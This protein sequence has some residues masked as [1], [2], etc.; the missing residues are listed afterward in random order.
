MTQRPYKILLVEDNPGDVRLVRECLRCEDIRYEMTHCENVEAAFRM[1][2]GYGG[3]D[4]KI[5]DLLLL[6]YNLPGGDAREVIHAAVANPALCGT[7]KAV[8]TSSFSPRDRQD[9]SQAGAEC[10][11]LKPA[12]LDLFLNEVGSAVLRLLCQESSPLNPKRTSVGLPPNLK[13]C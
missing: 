8:L 11:I 6:D 13:P 2:S 7:R 10:F 4:P 5:P 9:A 12:D 1:L 3:D